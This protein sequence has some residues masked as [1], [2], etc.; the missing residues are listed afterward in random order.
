VAPL[1]ELAVKSDSATG[2]ILEDDLTGV[3]E[4]EPVKLGELCDAWAA[5]A[6]KD[7]GEELCTGDWPSE[8]ATEACT[9]GEAGVA[10]GET[11]CAAGAAGLDGVAVLL[12]SVQ[13]FPFTV[14][15]ELKE[16]MAEAWAG[17]PGRSL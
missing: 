14:V 13:R 9:L 4:R 11:V 2:T 5:P 7:G 17:L 3:G 16:D 6:I 15:I 8:L 12:T 10:W 1:V